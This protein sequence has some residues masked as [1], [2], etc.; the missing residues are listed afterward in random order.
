MVVSMSERSL[1]TVSQKHM[2]TDFHF[3]V[4]VDGR[5]LRAGD[6][7]L[8]EAHAAVSAI[9]DEL[10]EF[11]D[12]SPVSRVNR[13][14]VGEWIEL[15]NHFRS[16]LREALRLQRESAGYFTPFA[17]SDG[18]FGPADLEIE[19][20]RIRKRAD[21]L[22]ISFGAIGKG[23]ALDQVRLLLER[24]GFFDYRLNCGG[25]SWILRGAN[26]DT[27]P[28]DIHWAWDRDEDG[29]YR[30]QSL[31]LRAD[32]SLAIGVS[33]VLEQG[34]HFRYRGSP[35]PAGI[36]SGFY[37]GR[38]A[39]EADALS[40]ALFVGASFEGAEIL[41]KLGSVLRDPSLAYVDKAG[42]IVY[43]RCFEKRFG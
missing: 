8:L 37:S 35:V 18:E 12:S 14:G 13:S 9:E 38:S 28:W 19:D 39:A 2:A 40:T 26:A 17:K 42:Q 11:R 31:S 32:E 10:S 25:S 20:A 41:T 43:N 27:A 22:R 4:V 16:L 3:E 24:H 21:G 30:G 6:S 33:G 23:Y 1:L 5:T 7:V 36:L 34:N 29:D 15:P